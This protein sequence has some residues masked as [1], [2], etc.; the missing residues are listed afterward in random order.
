MAEDRNSDRVREWLNQPDDPEPPIEQPHET[1]IYEPPDGDFD[2]L[3]IVEER[4]ENDSLP[5]QPVYTEESIASEGQTSSANSNQHDASNTQDEAPEALIIFSDSR[6]ASIS[7][8]NT[9]Q[10]RYTNDAGD[11]SVSRSLRN[12]D[13]GLQPESPHSEDSRSELQA[14]PSPP[15]PSLPSPST[16]PSPSPSRSPSPAAVSEPSEQIHGIPPPPPIEGFPPPRPPPMT[17]FMM[18]PKTK[19]K[20]SGRLTYEKIIDNAAN[21]L[22]HLKDGSVRRYSRHNKTSITFYDYSEGVMSTPRRIVTDND[23]SI[24][25]HA[26]AN[27]TRRL[28]LVEDLSKPTIDGLGITFSINPEFF[29][30]HLLNSNYAGARYHEPPARTWKTATFHKSHISFQWIRPV[31]RQPT[32]FSH[33]DLSDLLEESTEH[34]TSHGNVKT[35]VTTNIFR[36]EWNLWTDPTKSV[37]MERECGLE[38]RI[39]IWKGQLRGRG[40]EIGNT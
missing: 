33:R 14:S 17:Q 32:Y 23:I 9:Q 5:A 20:G 16:S 34:F 1:H 11:D 30:E 3:N 27:I 38:E 2:D 29:E 36:L 19:K 31:Y 35:T 12:E 18:L 7:D 21:V 28:I 24:L 10:S 6:S 4:Q 40:T 13:L 37:R 8:H 15:P 22:D 39:S 26:N 25:G